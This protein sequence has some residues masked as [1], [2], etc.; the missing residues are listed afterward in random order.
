MA[1]NSITRSGRVGGYRFEQITA[2]W[3]EVDTEP[4]TPSLRGAYI[5]RQRWLLSIFQL[6]NCIMLLKWHHWQLQKNL[7]MKENCLKQF[8][9]DIRFSNIPRAKTWKPYAERSLADHFIFNVICLECAVFWGDI[10]SERCTFSRELSLAQY[11][12]CNFFFK[13]TMYVC[14]SILFRCCVF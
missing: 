10:Q 9:L 13:F 8:V 3:T 7:R 12:L 5:Y 11:L 1:L 6:L 4:Q 2:H 14:K